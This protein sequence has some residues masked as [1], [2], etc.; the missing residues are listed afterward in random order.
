MEAPS[1]TVPEPMGAGLLGE[2]WYPGHLWATLRSLAKWRHA[3][4]EE[5]SL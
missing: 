3:A 1:F 5:E 4:D 2:E